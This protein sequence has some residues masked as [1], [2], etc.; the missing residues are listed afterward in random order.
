M[1]ECDFVI[2]RRFTCVLT[3]IGGYDITVFII[4]QS[5]DPV[6]V[7]QGLFIQTHTIENFG[8]VDTVDRTRPHIGTHGD[9]A[10]KPVNDRLFFAGS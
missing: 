5:H 8:G 6:H 7:I 9:H 10:L 4:G 3:M 1:I 2:K